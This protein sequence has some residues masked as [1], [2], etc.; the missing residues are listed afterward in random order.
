MATL[1]PDN[2]YNDERITRGEKTLLRALADD[3]TDDEVL[4][5]YQP[6][7]PSGR[8][9]DII[10]YYPELGLILYE[11]KDWVIEQILEAN[12]NEWLIDFNGK[13]EK[14]TAPLKQVKEYFYLLTAELQKE[15][16]FLETDPRHY[17]KLKIPIATAVAFPNI[18]SQQF[19]SKGLNKVLD[20]RFIIF[21]DDIRKVRNGEEKFYNL[22]KNHF[23][24][25]WFNES[26]SKNEVNKL[27][28]ILFPEITA[29]QKSYGGKKE[30]ITLDIHQQQILEKLGSGHRIIR[31]IAGS[32][33]SLI[34]AARAKK[35]AQEHP[36]WRIL[37][38]CYN[39]SL[40]SQLRY[41]IN[42]F[43]KFDL[44]D[45]QKAAI[46]RIE[47]KH[48]HKL[49]KEILGNIPSVDEEQIKK[50][51]ASLGKSSDQIAAAID[52]AKAATLGQALQVYLKTHTFNLYDAILVDE[53][54]DFHTT[55]LESLMLM[56]NKNTNQLLLAEDPAQ[57]VFPRTFTYEGVGISARGRIQRLPIAHRSTKEIISLA[58]KLIMEKE[59]WDD[60]FFKYVE[61]ED[62]DRE[63]STVKR[64]EFPELIIDNDYHSIVDRIV[65]DI[66]TQI[67]SGLR[68][69][70]FGILYL[71]REASIE[72]SEKDI[73][74]N[75]KHIKIDYVTPLIT[76]LSKEGMKYF[77]LSESRDSKSN[78]D[79]FQDSITISTIFSAKGLEFHTV[80]IVGLELFPWKER[81]KRENDSILYVA[82]TRARERVLL[83]SL[84]EN[85]ITK[86]IRN[87]INEIKNLKSLNH[88]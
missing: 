41:Y 59:N 2:A 4:V 79:Q 87:Y 85:E 53:V 36:D 71:M 28:A 16:E 9:P 6:K 84:K 78:Y 5:F 60:F 68:Y 48:F 32:G 76:S 27:R 61:N 31:G 58:T 77:W 11:V 19:K 38:T 26:L 14:K 33:K 24:P 8:R 81:N 63:S 15:K 69:N 55:W 34:I 46:E 35:L 21:K 66:K 75:S 37:I 62:I 88:N 80:Y 40:A 70:D 22:F 50:T 82:I 57:K 29:T 43:N 13:Y 74:G 45:V 39:I 23:A 73:F 25:W 67:E 47:V 44:S 65:N 20:R 12:P 1:I 52:E 54:Q 49:A 7:L 64:G 30:E 83:F 42:S 18:N 86:R 3:I 51:S 72:S 56:L 17:G 10:I